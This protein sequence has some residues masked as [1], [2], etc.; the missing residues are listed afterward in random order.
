MPQKSAEAPVL[1]VYAGGEPD[2]LLEEDLTGDRGDAIEPVAGD[3]S[4]ATPVADHQT[5]PDEPQTP[6]KEPETVAETPETPPVVPEAHETGEQRIPKSRFDQV[7]ERRK[8]AEQRLRELEAELEASKKVQQPGVEFDFDT[9]E[10]QYM[11]AVVDGEFDKA[12]QIR[13][14]IRNAERQALTNQALQLRDQAAEGAR[15]SLALDAEVLRLQAEFPV[16]DRESESFDEVLTAEAIDIHQGLVATG[17]YTPL[18]AIRKA[19]E[20]VA[21]VNGIVPAGQAP[22]ETPK[23]EP[24]RSTQPDIQ[25]KIDAA[26]KQPPVKVVGSKSADSTRGVVEMTEDEFN[27][28]P[29]STLR[30]LRGDMM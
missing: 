3:T 24:V 23:V 11:E 18:Q 8:L 26:N 10:Q 5:P 17:K 27:S 25:K 7:N 13:T 4:T 12:K 21:K 20:M 28:L 14:Q 1:D 15:Q 30:K 9:A 19:A 29:D 2:P 16:F 22:A 6:P